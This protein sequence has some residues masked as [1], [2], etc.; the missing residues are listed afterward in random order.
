MLEY[1]QPLHFVDKDKVG[2]KIVVR[3]AKEDEK[4]STLDGKE[5]VLKSSDIVITDSEKPICIAGV[6]G[7]ENTDV[8]SYIYSIAIE[9]LWRESFG[10]PGN[11]DTGRLRPMLWQMVNGSK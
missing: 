10:A 6:M 11:N 8:D 7:G 9:Q 4:I 5:R 3:D 1:G 2:N